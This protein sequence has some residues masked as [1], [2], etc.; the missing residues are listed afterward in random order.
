MAY[1]QTKIVQ[2]LCKYKANVNA[3]GTHSWTPLMIA[4]QKGHIEI[5]QKLLDFEA[6]INTK[7][8]NYAPLHL[9]VFLENLNLVD[10]FEIRSKQHP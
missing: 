7:E 4:V 2:I 3:R 9:A 1:G 6:E 5:A 10:G 8:K